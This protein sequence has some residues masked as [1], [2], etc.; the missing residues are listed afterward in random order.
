MKRF[1][2]A[3]HYFNQNRKKKY[4]YVADYHLKFDLRLIRK[5]KKKRKISTLKNFRVK[6]FYEILL[7]VGQSS[8]PLKLLIS[9]QACNLFLNQVI[10]MRDADTSEAIKAMDVE[11]RVR[12]IKQLSQC[13][14]QEIIFT[15]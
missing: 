12:G 11:N 13:Q 14:W 5:R 8:V 1:K 15:L 4:S 6:S 2:K 3:L 7:T 10:W 9:L